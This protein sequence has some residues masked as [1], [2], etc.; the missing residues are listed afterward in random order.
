MNRRDFLKTCLAA[1][2]GLGLARSSF[3]GL[4]GGPG[5][6]AGESPA[7]NGGALPDIVAVRNGEPGAMFDRGIAAMGGMGRFV[8]RGQTVAIKPNASWDAR[9]EMAGNTNPELVNRVARHCLEAGAKRVVVFDHA[10]EHW[11]RCLEVSGIGAAVKDAGVMLAPAEAE[12]YYHN[13]SVNGKTLREVKVHEAVLEADVLISLPILKHHG[14]AGITGSIKNF[15]GAVWDR[16]AYHARGLSQCIADFLL[17][18]KPD[19][20]VIDAYRILTQ[21]GPRS[22]SEKDV[23]LAKMQILSTDAV[24]ADASGARLLGNE[25]SDYEHLRIAHAMGFGELDPGK[26]VSR[27]ISL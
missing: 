27:R 4:V 16:R 10:I 15:M 14:G 11:Q 23:R 6:H 24:A 22:R 3:G 26:L 25:P 7:L 12:R 1:G 5:A 13:R 21:N 18:R 19:L 9:V 8:K 20:T 17:V 2:A